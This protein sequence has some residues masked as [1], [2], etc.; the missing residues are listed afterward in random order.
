MTLAANLVFALTGNTIAVVA[1]IARFGIT[2][3]IW[4][5]KLT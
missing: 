5:T 2:V 3:N 1:T 4:I